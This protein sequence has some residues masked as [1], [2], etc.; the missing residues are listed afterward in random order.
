MA[1]DGRKMGHQG[2]KRAANQSGTRFL[3]F[4]AVFQFSILAECFQIKCEKII[5][6]NLYQ[7][8]R[9]TRLDLTWVAS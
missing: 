4:E 5:C 2:L 3:K 6:C 8:S 7:D 9:L 1:Q